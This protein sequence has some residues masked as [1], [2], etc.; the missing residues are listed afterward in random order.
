MPD[1]LFILKRLFAFIG[2]LLAIYLSVSFITLG[3]LATSD[4]DGLFSVI[5]LSK[6]YDV[7]LIYPSDMR[8]SFP[9]ACMRT[10]FSSLKDLC[11][12]TD[13]LSNH[14]RVFIIDE[15]NLD[16][17]NGERSSC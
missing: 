7:A 17:L 6:S 10:P 8:S 4:S 9:Y 1:F 13:L 3:S 12:I 11:T 14:F 15:V 2:G 5:S 16:V